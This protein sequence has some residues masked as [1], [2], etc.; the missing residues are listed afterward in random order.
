MQKIIF[1]FLFCT[2]F[3]LSVNA[4]TI[5]L[6]KLDLSAMKNGWRA[7]QVNKSIEGNTLSIGGQKFNRG[8]GAHATSTFLLNI[9]GNGKR[10]SASVGVDDEA[11]SVGSVEFFI[12][13][14]KKT[15][16][17]S[18]IIRK[19]MAPKNIDVDIKGIKKLGLLITD[20][21]DG[22][23]ADHA[24]WCDAKFEMIKDV[25]L[26]SLIIKEIKNDKPYILTPKVSDHPQ[27]NG[28]KVFGVKAGNPFLYTVPAT[29]KRPITFSAKNLPE[30]LTINLQTGIITGKI[31]K[32][33]IY[34][35]TLT[36]QNKLGKTECG[37]TIS[38]GKTICLTPPM[39][40]NSWNCWAEAVDANKIKAA[41][42]AMVKSGLINH[43]WTYIN[44]DDGWTVQP[45]AADSMAL[46]DARD[47]NG[48]LNANKKFPDMKVLSSYIHGKGLK[49]GVYSSPGPITCAGYTASYK[50]EDLDALRY[51][52]WGVDYL[53]YDL[54]SYY[55]V[56]TSGSLDAS[57]R[58][59]KIM[60]ASLDKVNRDIVYS[61]CQYGTMN[62]WEWGTEVGGNCW[63][64][65]GDISDNWTYVSQIGFG[66]A[67]HEKYA[68]PGH[69]ND[70]DM[71]VVGMVGWGPY[72]HPSQLTADEQY[73]HISLWCLLSA[74]LLIGCDLTRLDDFTLN[75]LTN[76][77]VLAVDQDPLG[78]QAGRVLDK[79]GKQVWVKN[80][81]DGSI[82]VGIFYIGAPWGDAANYFNWDSSN[83]DGQFVLNA[84]DIGIK[85]KFKVRDLWRQKNLGSFS[86]EFSTTIPFHGVK[87]LKITPV[88]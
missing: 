22:N 71:L 27:I 86:N 76:D 5:W 54:C 46:G 33:G 1:S 29:G 40:W 17:Q 38:V 87:L 39:G 12:V 88:K 63:R 82:A 32:E 81:E 16:W 50:H 53:K 65:T 30:G 6:D 67:G 34:K 9:N 78:K 13:G 43:G 84:S 49:L 20:A 11:S 68:S 45:G 18:G 74:P 15:L 35:T 10:F 8:V 19:G 51:A 61:I 28:A 41:A 83:K 3:L 25:S 64:T 59:Y 48:M 75:L 66:Q 2:I 56:D 37:F 79:D 69:W 21:N 14:D 47:K 80:L 36:A 4:Q 58:P 55:K 57:Q 77:E 70:P 31:D 42:D 52:Q 26:S 60:R 24:D 7:P 85:G 23:G 44:I 73:S 72:L 62:V